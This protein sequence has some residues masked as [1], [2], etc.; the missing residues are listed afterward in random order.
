MAQM[1]R[2][3]DDDT[4]SDP[5]EQREMGIGDDGFSAGD[6]FDEDVDDLDLEEDDE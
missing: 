4:I 1:N 2:D 5:P 3:P 6:D